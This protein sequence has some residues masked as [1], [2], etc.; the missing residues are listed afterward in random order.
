M[1]AARS[2]N[3]DS[4]AASSVVPQ[5]HNARSEFK[6]IVGHLCVPIPDDL[7][8]LYILVSAK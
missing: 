2:M 1:R 8:V 6:N 5:A 3:T 7:G 4:T